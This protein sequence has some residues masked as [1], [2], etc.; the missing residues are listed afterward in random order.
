MTSIK[1]ENSL[2]QIGTLPLGVI[3]VEVDLSNQKKG[4]SSSSGGEEIPV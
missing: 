4:D 2:P 1:N 3:Q